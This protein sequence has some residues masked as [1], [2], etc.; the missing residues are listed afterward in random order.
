MHLIFIPK[1]IPW[2]TKCDL[3]TYISMMTLLVVGPVSWR[4]NFSV[5]PQC[6][7]QKPL[8]INTQ[9]Q[10]QSSALNHTVVSPCTS[11]SPFTKH[12]PPDLSFSRN[13]FLQPIKDVRPLVPNFNPSRLAFNHSNN[14]SRYFD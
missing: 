10:M 5:H 7:I 8:K 2:N 9:P 3:K 12:S 13:I 4:I 14:I 11:S 6:T 1:L